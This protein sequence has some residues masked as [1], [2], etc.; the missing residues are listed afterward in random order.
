MHAV[1]WLSNE[2][3]RPFGRSGCRWEDNIRTDLTEI[4]I[5]SCG[6]DASGC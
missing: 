3:N 5:G 6:P 4:R 2:W 1:F